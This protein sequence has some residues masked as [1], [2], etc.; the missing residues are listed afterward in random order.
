[1]RQLLDLEA[2]LQQLIAEHGKLLKHVDAYQS[3]MKA[4]DPRAMDTAGNLQEATRLRIAGLESRRRLLTQQIGR[5]LKVDGDVTLARIA[6]LQPARKAALLKLRDELKAVMTQIASRS[7]VAGKL[8][9]AVLGH[10]NTVVRLLAGAVEQ[11]G[12]YTKHGVP[13][14]SA[15]I[16]VMEAVA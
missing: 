6:E 9:G 7:H 11:A 16:G 2:I 5:L 15:R 10:L 13:R 14:V 3:A 1:M 8:A 12:V 4:V